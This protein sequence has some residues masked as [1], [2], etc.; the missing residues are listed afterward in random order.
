M[1]EDHGKP[2]IVKAHLTDGNF[3]LHFLPLNLPPTFGGLSCSILIAT[4]AR[5]SSRV[6]IVFDTYEEPWIKSCEHER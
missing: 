1:I 5:H 3:L 6:D 2:D 4:F